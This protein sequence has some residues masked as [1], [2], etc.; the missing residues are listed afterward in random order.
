MKTYDFTGEGFAVAEN[1]WSIGDYVGA[2][3]ALMKN[4]ANTRVFR[5]LR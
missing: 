1:F 5:C 2:M 3:N 4:A